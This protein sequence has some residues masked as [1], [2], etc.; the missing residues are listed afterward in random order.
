MPGGALRLGE[1]AG[2]LGLVVEGDCDFRVHGVAALEDAGPGDLAFV[3]SQA[4]AARAAASEAGAFVAPAGVD[5]D[6]RPVLRSRDPGRDFFRAARFILP[7]ERPQPGV[8]PSAVVAPD[9]RVHETAHVGPHCALGRGV[10]L[11]AGS[12]LYAGVTLYDEVEV[13]ADCVLHA[14]CVLAAR[15]VLSDRV[16][17]GPGVVLGGSGFGYVG[18]EQGGLQKVYDL[19]RVWVGD[20]VEIGA[21]TTVDRGTLGDTRIGRGSKID[22]LVQIAHNCTIG[23]NVVILAQVGVAGSTRVE[24]GAVLLAQAGVAGQLTVGAGAVVGP[25]SG[26]HKDVPAGAPVMGTPQRSGKAF[27]RESAALARLPEL[28]RRVRALER[29]AGERDD[30]G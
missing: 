21:N 18:A 11:G 22:N 10:S 27:H 19:G 25:Q 12:V 13:G 16:V 9:A 3:R 29:E 30:G 7:P 17:L 24:D 5:L 14:R 6:E 8:H 1:L 20:D 2:E 15:S 4:H 23:E 26:V 28:I